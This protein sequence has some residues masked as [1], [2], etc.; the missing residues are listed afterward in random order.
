MSATPTIASCHPLHRLLLLLGS[1]IVLLLSSC[2]TNVS[3]KV[4]ELSYSSVEGVYIPCRSER[5]GDVT[6]QS[7]ELYRAGGRLYVKGVRAQLVPDSSWL[8]PLN[9]D[10]RY[11]S[12]TIAPGAQP[13]E[14]YHE[15]VTDSS[16]L[17]IPID[18]TY[19][20]SR[21]DFA[22]RERDLERCRA[23]R[24][25]EGRRWQPELPVG[26]VPF[27]PTEQQKLYYRLPADGF[28]RVRG[29]YERQ[30]MCTPPE[31]KRGNAA[32]W[33]YPLAGVAFLCVDLPMF[34]FSPI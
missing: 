21:W 24:C 16:C 15:L 7:P 23:L 27:N 22:M 28:V 4:A 12:Y 14:V 3:G 9:K 8:Y 19:H 2:V 13:A 33:A 1:T 34:L 17:S 20:P 30:P 26:A 31:I 32:L 11:G 25:A 10:G 6:V 5:V 18:T 29:Y